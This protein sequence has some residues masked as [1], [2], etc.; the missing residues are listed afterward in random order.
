[1]RARVLALGLASCFA[2]VPAGAVTENLTGK[3]EGTLKC[4]T[5]ES[6]GTTKSKQPIVLNVDEDEGGLRIDSPGVGLFLDGVVFDEPEKQGQ[7]TLSAVGCGFSGGNLNG[8]GVLRATVKT[9]AGDL[10]ASIKGTAIRIESGP[11]GFLSIC[12]F[13]AKRTNATPD[14]LAPCV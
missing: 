8:S 12:T 7:G 11:D 13:T 14:P 3:W 4:S 1:M 2:A 6:G 10:K 9:K 5:A